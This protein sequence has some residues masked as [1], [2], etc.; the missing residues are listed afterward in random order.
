M[1]SHDVKHFSNAMFAHQGYD[2]TNLSHHQF[3]PLDWLEKESTNGVE[4]FFVDQ[5]AKVYNIYL[6]I[7]ICVGNYAS[8]C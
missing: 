3:H 2:N 6:I 5:V 7:Y 1:F 8:R 4:Y